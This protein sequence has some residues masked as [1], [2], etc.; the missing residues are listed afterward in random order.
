MLRSRLPS[1]YSDFSL[2][3]TTNP[4]GYT[5]NVTAWQ[6]ALDHAAQ[7]NLLPSDSAFILHPTDALLSAL[8][9]SQYGR[10][11]G[12]GAVVDE[13]VRSGSMI[14]S[15]EFLSADLS[16]YHKSWVPSPW[17]VLQWGLRQIGLAGSGGYEGTAGAR[18]LRAAAFVLVGA[19]EKVAAQ[20]LAKQEK[21]GMSLTDRILSR[22]VFSQELAAL[23]GANVSEEDLK[24]LLRYLERD[25]QVL[26]Y[27]DKVGGAD[28]PQ[29]AHIHADN[30]R[31]LSN[32]SLHLPSHRN[33]SQPRTPTSPP[34]S[35]SYQ[36]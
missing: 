19:L 22:E 5:A 12:L 2:Q 17:T 28:Q 33:Q 25:K 21:G 24:V 10:P 1:L 30:L 4:D 35:H 31:R 8:S 16:I 29:H 34:S 27:N 14:P 18:R 7:A 11:L 26:S 32:S 15:K 3:R 9:S 20:V 6:A 36:P 23:R 13:S